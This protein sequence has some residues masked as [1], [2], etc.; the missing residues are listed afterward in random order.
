MI[1]FKE[2]GNFRKLNNFLEKVKGVVRLSDLDKYGR[3]GV[4]L[5]EQT[6]PKRTGLTSRSWE[7]EIVRGKESASIS[8]YNTNT[9]KGV[10]IAIILQYGHATK[11]GG[12]VEGIDYINPTIRPLFNKIAEEAWEEVNN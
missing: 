5:L 4:R 6:T 2:Q 1:Q 9:N 7:Y 12:W 3:E 10:N 11:N 8:F